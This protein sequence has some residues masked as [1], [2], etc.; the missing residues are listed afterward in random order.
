MA[1]VSFRIV[2]RFPRLVCAIERAV[3]RCS[4]VSEEPWLN[5]DLTCATVEKVKFSMPLLDPNIAVIGGRGV[6]PGCVSG[7]VGNIGRG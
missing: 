4:W 3:L 5:I 7:I 2:K 6:I 1:V